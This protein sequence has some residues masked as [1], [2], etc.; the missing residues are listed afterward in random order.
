MGAK[1]Q[2]FLKVNSSVRNG[3]APRIN[4]YEQ[5]RLYT[6]GHRL[7][8]MANVGMSLEFIDIDCTQKMQLLPLG[9]VRVQSPTAALRQRDRAAAICGINTQGATPSVQICMS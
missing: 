5:Y 9:T 6:A 7:A 2:F 3:A 4:I 8:G 1:D